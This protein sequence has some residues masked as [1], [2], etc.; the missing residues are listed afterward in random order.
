M[1][2]CTPKHVDDTHETHVINAVDSDGHDAKFVGLWIAWRF[3]CVYIPTKAAAFT[4]VLVLRLFYVAF[5]PKH[6]EREGAKR[7]PKRSMTMVK[8]HNVITFNTK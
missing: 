3:S 8:T 6:H 7:I 5:P 1:N 4:F 2:L